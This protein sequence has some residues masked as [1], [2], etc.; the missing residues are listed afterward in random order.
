MKV[1]C[2]WCEQERK[3][4]LIDELGLNYWP[5]TSHGICNDHEKVIV[6]RIRELRSKENPRLHRRRHSLVNPR[7]S[8]R[9]PT[10]QTT[11]IRT[12]TRR[13]LLKNRLSSAQLR[14]PFTDF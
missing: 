14:L 8:T 1:I 3:Q 11:C 10:S 7:G 12:P 4:T 2:A 13:R 9:L 5:M 6:R